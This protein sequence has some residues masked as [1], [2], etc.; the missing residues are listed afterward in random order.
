MSRKSAKNLNNHTG[1]CRCCLRS[2]DESQK[3]IRIDRNIKNKFHSLTHI[4]L[5]TSKHYSNNICSLCENLLNFFH[6][7][8]DD[9][10]KNQRK[11]DLQIESSRKEKTKKLKGNE[12]ITEQ[13]IQHEKLQDVFKTE[14]VVKVEPVE[15]KDEKEKAE[16]QT[17]F[18]ASVKTE[19]EIDEYKPVP[20]FLYDSPYEDGDNVNESAKNDKFNKNNFSDDSWEGEPLPIQL[21]QRK[22]REPRLKSSKSTKRKKVSCPENDCTKF[23][24]EKHMLEDHI[25]YDH[26]G[27]PFQCKICNFKTHTRDLLKS[28]DFRIH[29]DFVNNKGKEQ[30]P[31]CGVFVSGLNAHIKQVHV[32]TH[33]MT[34]DLCGFGSFALYMIRRHMMSAHYPKDL[35]KRVSCPICNKKLIVSSGNVSLKAH[36]KNVHSSEN[37]RVQCYCGQY[38][39]SELYLKNHQR[40]VHEQKGKKHHCPTCDK[41]N[42]FFYSL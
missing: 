14:V 33:P 21:N 13:A 34:C 19:M 9:F 12:D 2:F 3:K 40:I 23:F 24:Y 4:E 32:K 11:L 26:L 29:G 37:Q 1:Q 27:I 8:R 20:S 22:K 30:C 7:C 18:V 17:V 31:E 16:I 38:Y 28:H 41:C 10:T 35:K 15:V 5:K 39:K 42:F 6:H 36:M 25:Q